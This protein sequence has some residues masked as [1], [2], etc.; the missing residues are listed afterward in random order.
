MNSGFVQYTSYLFN[1]HCVKI[2]SSDSFC[3]KLF[4]HDIFLNESFAN[5]IKANYGTFS[6]NKVTKEKLSSA[7]KEKASG[8]MFEEETEGQAKQHHKKKTK[9]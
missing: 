6:E 1:A 7:E 5:A 2:L 3:T 8:N 9:Q 4:L